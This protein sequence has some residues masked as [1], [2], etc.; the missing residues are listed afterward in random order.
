MEN[1]RVLLA[2]LLS[3]VVIVGWQLLFPPPQ[4]PRLPEAPDRLE[5]PGRAEVA[6]PAS[7][8]AGEPAPGEGSAG[9][10][11]PI[12]DSGAVGE[13]LPAERIA[14]ER[15][16]LV[17]LAGDGFRAELS[18]RGGALVSFQLLGHE[19]GDGGP[20]DLVR[21]RQGLPYPF[22]LVRTDGRALPVSDVLFAVEEAAAEDPRAVRFTYGGP[23]GRVSKRFSVLPNG[24]LGIEIE[25]RLEAPWGVHLGPGLRDP[26]ARDEERKFKYRGAV[27]M[28]V[29]EVETIAPD[30]TAEARPIPGT[31]LGWAGLE[32]TYFLAAVIPEEPLDRAVV[33]PWLVLSPGEDGPP[34]FEPVP[35][36]GPS[37]AQADLA[38]ELQV[39][40]IPEGDVFTATAYLGAKDLDR[41][42]SLPWRLDE[43]VRLGWFGFLARLFLAGLKWIHDHVVPNYGWAIVLM[44]L[45]IKI[46][47][48]PLTH[49]SYV[50]MQK[51][52]ELAPRMKAIR[53]KFK[54]KLKDKKGRPDLEQQRKMNEEISA[55]YR[56][57][58]VNPVGGCLPMLLQFPV[59][60]A[61]YNLL[62]H[63]VELRGAPWMLW[64]D[65]LSMHDPIYV[66]PVIMG[67][68][69]FVQQ[70]M[71][72][73]IG[74][75]MQ[76][77][78]M[79][80]L[81]VVFTFLFL[82]FPSGLVLYWL[83]NNLLTLAQQAVYQWLK[84][85]QTE[86]AGAA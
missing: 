72:P 79:M 22:A 70:R 7:R 21:S 52:Q 9:E 50:S 3:I 2:V 68:V 84:A 17:V 86:A 13:E 67:V 10:T 40:L 32:D 80:A 82:G 11:G 38:R 25:A 46:V 49:K 39:V 78:M 4:P 41:L 76:R 42:K 56:S 47:L 53:A 69:Q 48:L 14:G 15:E 29:G 43:T 63:A 55:L 37:G 62:S 54:G 85:R 57:E 61:F 44:T 64:I 58:G 74:D 73:A 26:T 59:L 24:L 51:M 77:R 27:Y 75:P 31:G 65:D 6:A 35:A 71:A 23:E 20:V 33:T 36:G 5:G 12:E 18:N 81:P 30:K 28:A 83:T 16:E 45:L 1:R 19:S 66:L 8:E 34:A 60:I